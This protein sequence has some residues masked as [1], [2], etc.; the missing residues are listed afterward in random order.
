M[1]SRGRCPCTACGICVTTCPRGIMKLIPVSQ[2]IFLGC[3]SLDKGKAVK[4]AC[5]VGCFGCTL[6][7]KE[8]VTPSGA[9]EMDGNLPVIKDI[10]SEDLKTAV[11]KCPTNSY[12]VRE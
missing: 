1:G 8:K 6:C 10:H 2:K 4:Q 9:I 7:A 12:V 5:K 11:E 3:V